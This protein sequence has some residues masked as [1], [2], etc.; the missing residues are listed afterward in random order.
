MQLLS[1][2]QQKAMVLLQGQGQLQSSLVELRRQYRQ[3]QQECHSIDLERNEYKE[4]IIHMEMKYR[5]A[6]Q[7]NKLYDGEIQS[8][9][10][11]LE[12]FDVEF[13]I[14]WFVT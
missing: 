8:L 11:L 6:N 2:Y 10:S 14:G 12:T 5:Q 7:Q 1:T 3:I 4:K 13:Q 9:R